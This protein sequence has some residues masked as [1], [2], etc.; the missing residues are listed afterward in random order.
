MNEGVRRGENDEAR[1]LISSSSPRLDRSWT[2]LLPDCAGRSRLR[3]QGSA[4]SSFRAS[5][6]QASLT[7]VSFPLSLVLLVE[8]SRSLSISSTLGSKA[9]RSPHNSQVG[10]HLG[11][12]AQWQRIV[13]EAAAQPADSRD[14]L[15]FS[16]VGLH[17][18]TVPQ[19]RLLFLT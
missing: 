19:V 1:I 6:P 3:P 9:D 15:F 12:L 7:S 18:L 10:N 5:S 11:A 14:S 4:A 2:E 13:K 17:A 8:P 16:V